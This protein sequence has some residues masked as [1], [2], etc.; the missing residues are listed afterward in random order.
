M[1]T[2]LFWNLHKKPLIK[3]IAHITRYYQIDV[4]I[5]VENEVEPIR[6][7]LE[8]N[9][10]GMGLYYYVPGRICKKVDIFTNFPTKFMQVVHET[11]RLTV[12]QLRLPGLTEILLAVTHF[13][14]KRSMDHE[15]Q[16][17]ESVHLS[18]QIK[19][20]E[21]KVENNK[22]ILVGDLNMNPFDAG[23]VNANGLNGV[24]TR[25]RALK[26]ERTV[27]G[28]TYPFFYNPMWNLFGDAKDG[29]PGTYFYDTGVHKNYYWNIFDQVL[30]R[31][32][33]LDRFSN[34]E[35]KILNSVEGESFINE[36]GI[37]DKLT[38]SDHLP[39]VFT[40]KL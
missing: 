6:I 28:V 3:Q 25:H 26:R 40:L 27:Q 29:S 13:V 2:F 38:A 30:V 17:S 16:I 39:L 1:T 14:D 36:N 32:D 37:P 31:P 12:R 22:T 24:M 9:E 34:Q 7:A 5:L 19:Y 15:S 23:V 4:V 11:E 10:L 18:S 21:E 33:L 35:L 20:A 8:L